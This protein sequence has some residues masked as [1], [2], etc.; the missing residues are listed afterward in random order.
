M[1][2]Y[3]TDRA[4]SDK[5]IPKLKELIGPHLMSPSSFEADTEQAA[6]LVILKAR[7]M[8]IAA[9]V[10]RFGYYA[11]FPNDFT[12]RSHRESGVKTE[13]RKIVEGWGDWF[14]YGHEYYDDLWP[15]WLINLE[16]L[17]CHFSL[18]WLNW[19]Y[20]NKPPQI[21]F[22]ERRNYDGKTKFVW[23]DLT[24]FPTDPS[25]IIA[26]SPSI[27]PDLNDMPF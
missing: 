15:W 16:A 14:F 21:R 20:A 25:L 4:W 26:R 5:W 24:S 18:E 27:P 23:F 9:R 7:D 11:E 10:R 6:D 19:R 2:E 22:G 13:L 8:H 17:R 3:E 1:I 12:I